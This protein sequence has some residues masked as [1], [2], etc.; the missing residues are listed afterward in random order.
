MNEDHIGNITTIIK[1]FSMLIAGWT[2]GKLA[3]FGLN[4]PVTESELSEFIGAIILL[5]LAYFDA[6]YPN[7]FM[8]K[9]VSTPTKEILEDAGETI[10]AFDSAIKETE[11][12]T[13][14]ELEV[15]DGD[16]SQ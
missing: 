2:I 13:E 10:D 11:D 12:N 8:E 14:L 1:A 7:T 6:K 4:L 5:V 3:A 15:V 9:P 16:D